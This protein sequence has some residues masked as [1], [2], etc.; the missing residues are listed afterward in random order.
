MLTQNKISTFDHP[1]KLTGPSLHDNPILA[2]KI[3]L[4]YHRNKKQDQTQ[5]IDEAVQNFNFDQCRGEYWNP[6]NY[7]LLYGTPIWNE[8][9]QSQ[10]IILNQL[11]WV[12]YYSQI[13]S[14]EIATILYNQTSAAGLYSLKD[15]RQVC[16]ML[17]LETSQERAHINA[18]YQVSSKVEQELFG[19]RIFSYEMRPYYVETMIFNHSH[20]ISKFWKKIQLQFYTM[21]SSSNAFI[22]CQYFTVRGLRTLKGKI[23]QQQLSQYYLDHPQKEKAP[24]P[25]QISYFHYMD[26]S[27]HFSSSHLIGSEIIELLPKPSTFEKNVANMGIRG[28]L[29]DH[30][31]FN[32][33][34]NGIFWY[35]PAIFSSIFKVL[36]SRHFGL[37]K[38][39]AIE[40]MKRSYC[41]DNDGVQAAYKTHHEAQE[42]YKN[43][44]ANL[45]YVDQSNKEIKLMK[46]FSPQQYLTLNQRKMKNFEGHYAL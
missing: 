41:Q 5:L 19:E 22:A 34:L 1:P 30:S 18:F 43:Y 25:S 11:Y 16:D 46:R 17:D 21:L 36:T 4:N 12:A 39:D 6:E 8:S 20:A 37:S 23:I 7:S 31:Y 35:E 44:L 9:T 15:F 45:E 3:S 32:V 2:K 38:S 40:M 10:K 24:I 33:T 14:A 27:Y 42:S 29:K 26:E 13:I 28:T